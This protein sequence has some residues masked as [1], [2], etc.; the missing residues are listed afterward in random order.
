[1]IEI[2]QSNYK[3]FIQNNDLVLVYYS[4]TWCAPCRMQE[5][6]LKKLEAKYGKRVRF[7]KIDLDQNQALAQRYEIMSVPIIMFYLKGKRVRFPSKLRGRVDKLLGVR[8]YDKLDGI[9]NHLV[10]KI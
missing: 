1:M 2:N 3:Q 4:A 5:P 10:K 8:Q 9:I 7:T 6:I